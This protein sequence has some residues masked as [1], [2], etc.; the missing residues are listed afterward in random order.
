MGKVIPIHMWKGFKILSKTKYWLSLNNGANISA[1]IFCKPLGDK[2]WILSGCET[3][4]K[5]QI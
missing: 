3:L 4:G 1:S 2:N 5:Y